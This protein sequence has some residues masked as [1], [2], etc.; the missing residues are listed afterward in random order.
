MVEI[1]V[2]NREIPAEPAR[3][4][5]GRPD[6]KTR[7][8]AARIPHVVEPPKALNQRRGCAEFAAVLV[9]PVDFGQF[10]RQRSSVARMI[11]IAA[12]EQV[13]PAALSL[14][15]VRT[16][17]SAEHES[18]IEILKLVDLIIVEA[19]HEQAWSDVVI[20]I[21]STSNRLQAFAL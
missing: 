17:T 7:A 13:E 4:L 8:V 21:D 5:G 14:E 18:Q 2:G 20:V 16:K 12:A 1:T 9:A 11:E 3:Q 6:V 19:V 15:S 10:P